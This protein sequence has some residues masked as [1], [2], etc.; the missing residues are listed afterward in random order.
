MTSTSSHA[1]PHYEEYWHSTNMYSTLYRCHFTSY[2]E[3]PIYLCNPNTI[4]V[5]DTGDWACRKSFASSRCQFL[6]PC[7]GSLTRRKVGYSRSQTYRK[8]YALSLVYPTSSQGEKWWQGRLGLKI[9]RFIS[10]WALCF[11]IHKPCI[12]SYIYYTTFLP[13][14]EGYLISS[15]V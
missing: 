12:L 5:A 6:L 8:Q 3:A 15:R 1:P 10:I 11:S 9:P 7:R 13:M 4:S 14:M 2:R